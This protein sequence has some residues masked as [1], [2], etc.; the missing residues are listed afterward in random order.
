MSSS[1]ADDVMCDDFILELIVA[2]SDFND[3][4]FE[5]NE[6]R[7]SSDA[8]DRIDGSFTSMHDKKLSNKIDTYTKQIIVSY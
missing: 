3:A 4:V 5:R 1:G 7:K 6:C 8:V 2:T